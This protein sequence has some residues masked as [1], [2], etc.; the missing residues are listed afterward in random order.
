MRFKRKKQILELIDTLKEALQY[1]TLKS[2]AYLHDDCLLCIS[3][4]SVEL[5]EV[6]D[7]EN[8]A[9]C[10]SC[11]TSIQHGDYMKAYESAELL[12]NWLSEY[13]PA[14][15]E[16][17]FLP[18]KADM[19]DAL[20]SVWEAASADPN[21]IV[22]TIPIPY[23]SLD[24]QGRPIAEE[25]EGDRFPPY[26]DITHYKDYDLSSQNPDV[27]F[28]HNPYDGYNRVTRVHPEYFSSNLIHYTEKLVYIP[29]F[30]SLG[31]TEPHFINLPGIKN[32]WRVF[33]QSE[34]TRRDYMEC[35]ELRPDQIVAM[36]TP[37]LDFLFK[38]MQEGVP[39]PSEWE[40]KLSG[41]TVFFYNSSLGRL[42][43]ENENITR[44]MQEIFN[45]FER[46]QDIA[47]IW[48]PH[49]LSIK[50]IMSMRPHLLSPYLKLVEKV[51]NMSNAVYDESEDMDTAIIHSDAYIGDFSSVII[52][53]TYTGKPILKFW[54]NMDLVLE[55]FGVNPAYLD[56]NEE[57]NVP[58]SVTPG[59]IS[60]NA[61]IFAAKNRGGIFSLDLKSGDLTL[62]QPFQ[63]EKYSQPQLFV[64]SLTYQD[65]VWFV[66]D[67]SST[68]VSLNFK[69]GEINEYS[70][71]S[72]CICYGHKHFA[73]AV[74][75]EE[76]LWM[77]PAQSNMVVRL[78]MITGE[79][80]GHKLYPERT[81][82]IHEE[83]ICSDGV[84][85][86]GYL[87]IALQGKMTILQMDLDSGELKVHD[88]K[89]LQ[90][91]IRSITSDGQSLWLI[92]EKAP[93]VIKWNPTSDAVKEFN[94][95]PEG[96]VGGVKPFSGAL[97][98]GMNIWLV[99][100]E[101]N[102]IIK[103]SPYS[104]EMSVAYATLQKST[105][106]VINSWYLFDPAG[107]PQGL[108]A[109]H[110]LF[111]GAVINQD[112]IWFS[113][114]TAP[115]MIGININT[116]ETRTIPVKFSRINDEKTFIINRFPDPIQ[117]GEGLRSTFNNRSLPLTSFIYMVRDKDD[118]WTQKQQKELRASIANSDGSCGLKIWDHI[119]EH[120]DH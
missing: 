25:Y 51:K 3:H 68:V 37:K 61:F 20:D 12:S 36:G 109:D 64:K 46:N 107:K 22:R 77:L 71:P 49:P 115:E 106:A 80:I 79:M 102:M 9:I 104:E 88:L 7:N 30:I 117:K 72:D 43:V 44:S 42:L 4:I 113:P 84:I 21:C 32:A 58:I 11:E 33:V 31:E 57:L 59:S 18:Y 95:F 19:W 15:Y 8:M 110:S 94:H 91:P 47:I 92:F 45:F 6:I 69:S 35:K 97:F 99:P 39:M 60:D 101:A 5:Q 53:Y 81:I 52:P 76:Y 90:E 118:T 111:S 73:T 120:L 27:I 112:W 70:L 93:Y 82:D 14:R 13:V 89:F 26:V 86:N 114:V 75:H 78:N 40:M 50:T 96:F 28:I 62:I 83:S 98:D 63:P 48:R 103:V 87:W 54:P 74:Q 66:P 119:I 34:L 38:K 2:A 41:R 116:N 55:D 29:Y 1:L 67:R 17:V 23:Q 108:N 100:N 85:S 65:T 24:T 16:I 10:K 56:F 105:W